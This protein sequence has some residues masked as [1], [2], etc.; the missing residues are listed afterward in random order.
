VVG[1]NDAVPTADVTQLLLVRQTVNH[2]M[3]EEGLYNTV[4]AHCKTGFRYSPGGTDK[5]QDKPQPGQSVLHTTCESRKSTI[6]AGTNSIAS[7]SL[8]VIQLVPVS[9]SACPCV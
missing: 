4:V 9:N 2:P 5:T 3:K 6:A 8:C 7:L 1:F